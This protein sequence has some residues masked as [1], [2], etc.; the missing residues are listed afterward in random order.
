MNEQILLLL[1]I[2]F[3]TVLLSR[4]YQAWFF[5]IPLRAI[6]WDQ[7]LWEPFLNWTYGTWSD[8]LALFSD[9]RIIVFQKFMSVIWILSALLVW[10]KIRHKWFRWLL[11]LSFL[12]YLLLIIT[13][14]KDHF[15]RLGQFFEFTL[16]LWVVAFIAFKNNFRAGFWQTSALVALL[17]TF[18]AH[19]FYALGWYPR[20]GHFVQMVVSCFGVNE[21]QANVFLTVAGMMDLLLIPAVLLKGR[22]RLFA[23]IYATFWGFM[24]SVARL[25][26]Y[27]DLYEWQAYL[28]QWLPQFGFRTA[29]FVVPLVLF[30]LF[31]RKSK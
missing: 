1:R 2:C 10:L 12:C 30:L 15:Y 24:T 14:G 8:W 28:H 13:D 17:M 9:A 18:T 19:G 16:Q 20:P 25:W 26:A 23:L 31:W 6:L 3:S 11:I 22:W 21:A 4:A 27:W 7:S 29:H 5:D